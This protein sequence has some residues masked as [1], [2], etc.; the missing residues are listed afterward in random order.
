MAMPTMEDALNNAL[1]RHEQLIDKA[2]EEFQ[3]Q[4]MHYKARVAMLSNEIS[5]IK[6]DLDR[7]EGDNY[8]ADGLFYPKQN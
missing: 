6:D 4:E 7:T 5:K 2:N 8:P 1:K 3:R